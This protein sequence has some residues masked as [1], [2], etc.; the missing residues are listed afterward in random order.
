MNQRHLYFFVEGDD[1]ERFLK[2]IVEPMLSNHYEYIHIYQY[3]Q[4]KPRKVE[5]FLKSIRSL[6]SKGIESDY[7]L[8][9][10]INSAPCITGK[11][12]LISDRFDGISNERIV[13]VIEEIESWYLA[14]LNASESEKL[15]LPVHETTD[16]IDKSRFDSLKPSRFQSRIDFM[17]EILK[18]FSRETACDRNASLEYFFS[19][20]KL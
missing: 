9:A 16:H 18:H 15:G 2:S 19:K 7:I 4:K 5:E 17:K 10:D 20:L 3:A 14:G 8:I 1:D 6:N 11:K 13:I 12:K